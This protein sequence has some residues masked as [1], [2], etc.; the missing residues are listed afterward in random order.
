MNDRDDDDWHEH[1]DEPR[2]VEEKVLD[3]LD[4]GDSATVQRLS[5][6]I[7][8]NRLYDKGQTLGHSLSGP[9]QS[10][11]PDVQEA[12]LALIDCAL[13]VGRKDIF[14]PYEALFKK[15]NVIVDGHRLVP[16]EDL[17]R[18]GFDRVL[19][20]FLDAGMDPRNPMQGK[21]K[22]NA[23]AIEIAD[24]MGQPAIAAMF[25]AHVAR[26][27]VN[28]SLTRLLDEAKGKRAP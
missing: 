1:E 12:C 8:W 11:G 10:H 16:I 22:Y 23:S 19:L 14:K 6:K 13:K 21:G 27:T 4:N 15:N 20:R 2:S 26:K 25:R 7:D 18:S 9:F 28:T 3:A 17:I 24:Q 5:P